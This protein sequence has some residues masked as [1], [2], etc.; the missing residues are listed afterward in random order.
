MNY[1]NVLT[2]RKRNIQKKKEIKIWNKFLDDLIK[3]IL[4]R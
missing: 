2:K 1:K 3:T 4:R